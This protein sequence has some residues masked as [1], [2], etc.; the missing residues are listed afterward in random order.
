MNLSEFQLGMMAGGFVA[1]GL[2][3]LLFV[4]F[5]VWVFAEARQEPLTG[6]ERTSAATVSPFR[7]LTPPLAE[8]GCG[9]QS[10]E[11]LEDERRYR[12]TDC[13]GG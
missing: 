10:L 13:E 4:A 11:W 12:C 2:G 9:L 7:V 5:V 8:C 6:P 1:F 3:F